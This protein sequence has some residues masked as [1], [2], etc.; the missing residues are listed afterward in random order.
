[1]LGGYE[2][3]IKS[4]T[5]NQKMFQVRFQIEYFKVLPKIIPYLKLIHWLWLSRI[6]SWSF[7]TL[8]INYFLDAILQL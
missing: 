8:S 7:E 2:K 1:M 6:G 4:F 3:M 5:K